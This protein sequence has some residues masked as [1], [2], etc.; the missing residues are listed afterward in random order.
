MPVRWRSL[1]P[2]KATIR[3][4]R[5]QPERGLHLAVAD[6]LDMALP[7]D[8]VWHHSPNEWFGGPRAH[9]LAALMKRKGTRSG[10]PDVEILF[11]REI[12]FIE[13][14]DRDEPLSKSQNDLHPKICNTGARLAICRSVAEV[15]AALDVWDI[16]LR[17]RVFEFQRQV[18]A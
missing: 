16:P 10:W 9:A 15:Q 5:K 18:A 13:L 7:V 11:R 3:G 6:Y 1:K 14:K 17:A 4:K 8:A 2:E 12:Y